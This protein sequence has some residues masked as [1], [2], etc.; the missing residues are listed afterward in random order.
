MNAAAA[1]RIGAYLLA[2]LAATAPALAGHDA[3]RPAGA[4]WRE[5]LQRAEAAL[6]NGERGAAQQAWEQAYRAAMQVRTPEGLLAVGDAYL[7]I[8]EAARGR[9]TAVAS[10]RRIFL[11]A[12]F[13]ARERRDA[14]GVAAA[15]AA[16]AALGDRDV[17]DRGFEI[18]TAVAHRHGDVAVRERIDERQAGT[19][20][21]PRTP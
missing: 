19:A 18:A 15:A 14:P 6:A 20:R 2:V 1:A 3:S 17:A 5:P 11:T 7:R 8:G 10:A 9:P 13:Q 4:D 12:L 16:F 21:V